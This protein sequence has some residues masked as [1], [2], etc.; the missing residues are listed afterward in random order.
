MNIILVGLLCF[1]LGPAGPTGMEMLGFAIASLTVSVL[2][3]LWRRRL[4]VKI[5][6]EKPI[7]QN[8]QLFPNSEILHTDERELAIKKHSILKR[9]LAI[10]LIILIIAAPCIDLTQLQIFAG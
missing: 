6:V 1:D 7:I 9:S 4:I 10:G 8:D 3:L 5:S 2:L